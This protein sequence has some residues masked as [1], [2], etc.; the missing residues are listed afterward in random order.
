[1]MATGC[2]SYLRVMADLSCNLSL[3]LV[4]TGKTMG[5]DWFVTPPVTETKTDSQLMTRGTL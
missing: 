1:M 4:L 2:P 3:S 5:M